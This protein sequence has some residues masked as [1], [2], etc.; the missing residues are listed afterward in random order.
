MGGV[1]SGRDVLELL[2]AGA[3]DVAL[4]TVLFANPH[5]PGRIRAELQAELEAHDLVEPDNA[6]GAAH[7]LDDPRLDPKLRVAVEKSLHTGANMAG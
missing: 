3:S 5:T 2:A 7:R 1:T 4:G 6:V